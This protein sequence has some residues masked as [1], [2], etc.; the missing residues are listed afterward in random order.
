MMTLVP[1]VGSFCVN[2]GDSQL[3][4]GDVDAR[5]PSGGGRGV[6]G[7]DQTDVVETSTRVSDV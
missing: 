2:P 7:C 1:A 3:N 4:A 5:I 6:T